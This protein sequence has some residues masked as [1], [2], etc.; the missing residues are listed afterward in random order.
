[1]IKVVQPSA[2]I[3]EEARLLSRFKSAYIVKYH[4]SFVHEEKIHIVME[5][6][7]RGDLDGYLKK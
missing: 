1:M 5:L 6:C 7:S 3:M 4:D 2:G